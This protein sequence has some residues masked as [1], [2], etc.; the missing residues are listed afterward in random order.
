MWDLPGPGLEPVSLELAGGVSST[1]PPGKSPLCG[2]DS[3][4]FTQKVQLGSR[5]WHRFKE[6]LNVFP[7]EKKELLV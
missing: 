4:G 7:A 2:I 5:G 1:A 6:L 3:P